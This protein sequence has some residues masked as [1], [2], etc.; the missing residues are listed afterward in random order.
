M[1]SVDMSRLECDNCKAVYQDVSRVNKCAQC[2]HSSFWDADVWK[3][4]RAGKSL[5]KFAPWFERQCNQA[6]VYVKIV[7]MD[8]NRDV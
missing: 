6:F 3:F 2:G 4:F 7:R 1:I 5:V 8:D